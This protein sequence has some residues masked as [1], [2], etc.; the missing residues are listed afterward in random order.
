MWQHCQVKVDHHQH[1]RR[2]E[3]FNKSFYCIVD[4]TMRAEEAK[5]D[6]IDQVGLYIVVIVPQ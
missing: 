3:R 6:I 4:K 1:Q 5:E 2:E